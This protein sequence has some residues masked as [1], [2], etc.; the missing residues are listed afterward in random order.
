MLFYLHVKLLQKQCDMFM[1]KSQL[2]NK[3]IENLFIIQKLS[4]YKKYKKKNHIYEI[5]R[6][7]I[8]IFQIFCL[9]IVE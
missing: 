9:S 4:L 1:F 7:F 5:Y 8:A 2:P 3:I 6:K